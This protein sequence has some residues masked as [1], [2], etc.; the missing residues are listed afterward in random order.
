MHYFSSIEK[1]LQT[2]RGAMNEKGLLAYG[3]LTLHEMDDKG[4][5][6]KLEKTISRAHARYFKPSEIKNLIETSGFQVARMKTISYRK[7]YRSL[8]EDKGEY[9]NVSPDQLTACVQTA[10][11]EAKNQ[12][13]LTDTELTLYYTMIVATK[14]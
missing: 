4:F 9:F 10:D 7:S 5:L 6:E 13:G 1:I 2:L 11:A 3:D 14:N 8:M 12:Y